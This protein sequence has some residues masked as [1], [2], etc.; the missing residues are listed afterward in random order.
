[1]DGTLGHRWL[2]CGLLALPGNYDCLYTFFFTFG[3]FPIV[4]TPCQHLYA[5]TF[6]LQPLTLPKSLYRWEIIPCLT[7]FDDVNV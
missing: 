5:A 3:S 6:L 1:M 2:L 4:F 7:Q